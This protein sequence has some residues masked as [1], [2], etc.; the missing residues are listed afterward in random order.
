[1]RL[2][3]GQHHSQTTINF[4]QMLDAAIFS[5]DVYSYEKGKLVLSALYLILRIEME[6]YIS[7]DANCY[8][9]YYE[10]FR[11]GSP[12]PIY[13]DKYGFN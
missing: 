13:T 3:T 10:K 1:M 6:S 7:N 12:N 5:P 2:R 4:L 8:R 9:T 11:K